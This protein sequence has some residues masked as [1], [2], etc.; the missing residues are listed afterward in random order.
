MTSFNKRHPVYTQH[1]LSLRQLETLEH[2]ASRADK[3]AHATTLEKLEF[4]EL[5]YKY[6]DR[7]Y[8]TI[9]GRD[10]LTDARG[11]GWSD[12]TTLDEIEYWENLPDD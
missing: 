8:I 5:I 12:P 6:G 4:C 10:A 7:Y 11:E 3:I 2:I 1:K 9:T